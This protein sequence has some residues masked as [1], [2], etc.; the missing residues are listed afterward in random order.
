MQATFQISANGNDISAKV[1][2]HLLSL[3][4]VDNGGLYSDTLELQLDDRNNLIALLSTGAKLDISL[5]MLDGDGQ[6]RIFPM[7]LYVVDEIELEGPPERYIIRAKSADMTTNLKQHN[8]RS[9]DETTLGDIVATIAAEHQLEPRVSDQLGQI[10]IPHLSQ[11]EE[12]DLHL[13]TRLAV[14]YDAIVE[15][16]NDYLLF[17]PKG[18]SVTVSGM[19]IPPLQIDKSRCSRWRV[20]V[21]DRSR[22]NSVIAYWHDTAKG[23]RTAEQIGDGEPAYTLLGTRKNQP[24][25]QLAAKA[26]LKA[27]NRAVGRGDIKIEGGMPALMAQMPIQLNG[28]REGINNRWITTRVEHRLNSTGLVT[29]ADIE[30]PNR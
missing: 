24:D 16:T 30:A 21:A 19:Q 2:E 17:M 5:G 23:L 26:Q 3:S 7:G 13:L 6:G 18:E 9:W 29:L 14:E 20:T 8:T 25:A 12:S 27:L 22:Y 28:W 15:P 10:S 4:I 11:T 1:A